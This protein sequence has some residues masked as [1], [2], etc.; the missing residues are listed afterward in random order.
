MSLLNPLN[1]AA[2]GVPVPEDQRE[3]AAAL[4]AG[5]VS[6]RIF[7]YLLFRYGERGHKFTQ[8]HRCW[9]S[10]LTRHNSQEVHA[11][12]LWLRNILSNRGIPSLILDTHLTVLNR[13]LIRSLPEFREK[14]QSL[15]SSA[16]QLRRDREA[17]IARNQG[18][19]LMS[20]FIGRL[21][22]EPNYFLTGTARMLL[23]AVA[24]EKLGV[25]HAVDSLSEWLLN[26]SSLETQSNYRDQLSSRYRALYQSPV[27]RTLWH[28]AVMETI[29]HARKE[30]LD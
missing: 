27:F 24:D 22:Q 4:R 10:S 25:E 23:A 5:R 2:G 1:P 7:P 19:K 9:L 29:K 15:T 11:Q 20:D 14:Y 21:R 17:I 6:L 3:I 30:S 12:I 13:Q 28:S 8:S 26:P 18:D 16:K